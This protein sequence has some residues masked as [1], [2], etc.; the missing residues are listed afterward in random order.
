M[1][2]LQVVAIAYLG[3]KKSGDVIQSMSQVR[4]A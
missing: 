4:I 2:P 1:L 3:H